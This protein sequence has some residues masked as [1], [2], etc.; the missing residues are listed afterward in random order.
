[1]DNYIDTQYLASA[2]MKDASTFYLNI[3][4]EVLHGCKWTCKGCHVDKEV[5][6][7]IGAGYD[8]RFVTLLE[9][10]EKNSYKPF[11]AFIAPTDF[12]T[13]NNTVEF[14]SDDNT[15]NL[16]HHFRRISLQ[17]TYL[18]VE[19]EKIT[20]IIHVLN[21]RYN[22]M[23]LE[24]NMVIEPAQIMNEK[25]LDTLSANKESLR[26][27]LHAFP[28][29]RSFGI[30]N[31][32]DYSVTKIA[33]TLQNYD[34]T[35]EKIKHLFDTTIDYN[36]SLG[37]NNNLQGGLFEKTVLQISGLFDGA[38]TGRKAQLLRF[39]FGKLTDSLIEKQYNYRNGKFYAS[40]LLYERY[41][42]FRTELEVPIKDWTARE[43]EE[44]EYNIQ[45]SQYVNVGNKE[46]CGD[47]HYLGACVDRGVLQ[48]MDMYD[49]TKCVVSRQA[50]D[51]INLKMSGT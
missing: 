20:Q 32:F 42:N 4:F 51:A 14:L 34:G 45:L 12:L 25:Y 38:I 24:I 16:L 47:C 23:E 7:G 39:S 2:H 35:H 6:H 1:M 18:E 3:N 26:L 44:W 11:I 46:S 19:S 30:F 9:D 27:R 37:R 50:L 31:V 13:A 8:E 22:D 15:C 48:L 5:Q 10:F 43:F 21:T 17:T 49:I 33:E 40:P 41:I 29:I 36:F 28:K